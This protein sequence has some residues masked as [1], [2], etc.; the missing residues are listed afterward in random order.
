PQAA[1]IAHGALSVNSARRTFTP[2]AHPPHSAVV[3]VGQDGLLRLGSAP[4]SPPSRRSRWRGAAAPTPPTPGASRGHGYGVVFRKAVGCTGASA[5]S[6]AR[7]TRRQ[8][9]A[10]G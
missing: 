4:S 3:G 5:P 1:T 6:G 7:A 9:L 2:R 8:R 10:L